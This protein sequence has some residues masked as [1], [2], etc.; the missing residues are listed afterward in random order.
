MT[1]TYLQYTK[2]TSNKFWEVESKG[3]DLIVRY[4]RIGSPGQTKTKTCS[5][6]E[7]ARDEAL[8][9]IVG[10]RQKGYIKKEE[11]KTKKQES[12]ATADLKANPSWLW[13]FRKSFN[14]TIPDGPTVIILQSKAILS[15]D[16]KTGKLLARTKWS[17]C[18]RPHFDGADL[19]VPKSSG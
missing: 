2:G 17:P 16:P 13:H 11:A 15:L 19:W 8:R 12:R 10:K 14:L 9:L 6:P 18:G 5:S 7:A 3:T 1:K 4:G